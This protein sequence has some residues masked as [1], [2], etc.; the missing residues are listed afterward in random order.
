[1]T[2]FGNLHRCMEEFD[3]GGAGFGIMRE[4]CLSFALASIVLAYYGLFRGKGRAA[5]CLRLLPPGMDRELGCHR[6]GVP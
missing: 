1:M 6:S 5:H 2:T 4:H 3:P